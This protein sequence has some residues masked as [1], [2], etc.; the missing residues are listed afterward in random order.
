LLGRGNQ[1]IS[2]RVVK[3]IG[4]EN[5]IIVA[6]PGKMAELRG[7]PLLVDTGD[8]EADAMLA[9]FHRVKIGYWLE[10]AHKI[11]PG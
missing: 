3:R 9:G 7:R 10:R 4:K 5:V 11:A 8:A 6:T 2:G 1:Q